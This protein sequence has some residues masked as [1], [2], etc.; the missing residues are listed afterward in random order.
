VIKW[1][2][3]ALL[4]VRDCSTAAKKAN[5]ELRLCLSPP[6]ASQRLQ[7]APWLATV[8]AVAAPLAW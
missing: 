2:L 5:R 8:A 7:Q 3:V 1:R 4:K 6:P